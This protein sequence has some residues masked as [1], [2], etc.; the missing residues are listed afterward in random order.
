MLWKVG[1]ATNRYLLSGGILTQ[2]FSSEDLE[3][4]PLD[5]ISTPLTQSF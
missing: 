1:S 5:V 4:E 2:S 3:F